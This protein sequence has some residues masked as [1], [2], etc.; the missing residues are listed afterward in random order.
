MY[1]LQFNIEFYVRWEAIFQNVTTFAFFQT[2]M[3]AYMRLTDMNVG[4]LKTHRHTH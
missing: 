1:V 2:A 4:S 3:K